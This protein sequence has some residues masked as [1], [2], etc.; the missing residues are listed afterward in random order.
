MYV[1]N[2]KWTSPRTYTEENGHDYA[3]GG[4]I[5]YVYVY[6]GAAARIYLH[7]LAALAVARFPLHRKAHLLSKFH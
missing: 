5:K 4:A 6:D 3:N 1:F 2:T 7:G